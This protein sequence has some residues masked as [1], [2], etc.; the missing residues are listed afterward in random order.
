MAK[1]AIRNHGRTMAMRMMAPRM[2]ERVEKSIRN[3]SE[4]KSAPLRGLGTGG[5]HLRACCRWCRYLRAVRNMFILCEDALTFRE[6]VHDA[7]KGLHGKVR[8]GKRIPTYY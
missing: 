1:T 7:T 4:S 6:T 5:T 2:L 3:E 8:H